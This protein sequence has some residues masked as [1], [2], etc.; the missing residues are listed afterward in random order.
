[1]RGEAAQDFNGVVERAHG[2]ASRPNCSR[3]WN[4]VFNFE[5][6]KGGRQSADARQ[7]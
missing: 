3:K 2:L 6:W 7:F 1:V 4:H 5:T